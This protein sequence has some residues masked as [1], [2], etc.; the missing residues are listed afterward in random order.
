MPSVAANK[1]TFS[2]A[3]AQ[4]LSDWLDQELLVAPSLRNQL[5]VLRP[6]DRLDAERW[7][8]MLREAAALKP[9]LLAPGVAIGRLVQPRHV[10]MLGYLVLS[11]R[12]IGEA[13]MAYHRYEGLFYSSQVARVSGKGELMRI[14]WPQDTSMGQLADTVSITAMIAFL[15]RLTEDDIA[16]A[17]LGFV[18]PEPDIAERDALQTYFGCPVSFATEETFVDMP[19]S[20]MQ[21]PLLHNDSGLRALLNRQ[22]EALLQASPDLDPFERSLQ[23]VMAR[24][25]PEKRCSLKVMANEMHVSVRTLQ[26]RLSVRNI[27]WQALL[28]D[29]R[30]ALAEEYLADPTL[31]LVDIALLLGFSEQSAFSRAYQQWAGVSPGKVRQEH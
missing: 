19:V 4:L 12:T 23:K 1:M 29:T 2:G 15:R 18:F 13:L 3:W 14:S 26:R 7:K 28:N 27:S 9:E 24:L 16:P 10:G 25:L 17:H 5:D 6:T 22:A 21:L 8:A 11:C 30:L 31:S 20:F